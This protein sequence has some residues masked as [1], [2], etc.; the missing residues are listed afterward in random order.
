MEGHMGAVIERHIR[1]QEFADRSGY[2]IPTIRKKIARREIAY[3]KVGRIITI[4]ESE[5]TR[6][7]GEL[8][9]PVALENKSA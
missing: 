7:L 1:V 4:P 2:A 8:R 5:L 3:R 9:E 6:I